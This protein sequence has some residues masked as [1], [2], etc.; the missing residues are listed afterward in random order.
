MKNS[1]CIALSVASFYFVVISIPGIVS[2][3]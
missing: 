1:D 3:F 2:L